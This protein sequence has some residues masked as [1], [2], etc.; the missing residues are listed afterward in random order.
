MSTP[1]KAF[2]KHVISL[3][4][5]FTD[6]PL[7]IQIDGRTFT[8]TLKGKGCEFH[9]YPKFLISNPNFTCYAHKIHSDVI[10]FS[11]WQHYRR[12]AYPESQQKILSHKTHT[13]IHI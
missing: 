9:L 8:V 10:A 13:V 3:Y 11:G 2:L 1:N 7:D 5:S 6:L 4:E 12:P